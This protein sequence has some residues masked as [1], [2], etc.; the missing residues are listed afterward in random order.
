[1][2]VQMLVVVSVSLCH[3]P[4]NKR[5]KIEHENTQRRSVLIYMGCFVLL[6]SIVTTYKLIDMS[7]VSL[8]LQIP[9][10]NVLLL[11]YWWLLFFIIILRFA[12]FCLQHTH[13][14]QYHRSIQI[15]CLHHS[16][17]SW[18]P[19]FWVCT[20]TVQSEFHKWQV[21]CTVWQTLNEG[22]HW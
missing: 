1:M 6:F 13:L 8:R 7:L 9:L 11:H 22:G 5:C 16:V 20:C 10:Y 15:L 18:E 21:Y 12:W 4:V 17:F 14:N 2:S 3:Q 19:L